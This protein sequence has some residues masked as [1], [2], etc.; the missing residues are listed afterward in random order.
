MKE[1]WKEA[2]ERERLLSSPTNNELR[3]VGSVCMSIPIYTNTQ[4]HTYIT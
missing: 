1:I 3:V 4:T 2:S